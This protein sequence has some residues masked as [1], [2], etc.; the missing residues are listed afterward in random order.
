MPSETPE[1]TQ[2]QRGLT[3]SVLLDAIERNQELLS[4]IERF[5]DACCDAEPLLVNVRA[6]MNMNAI[7]LR[8]GG[9][10]Q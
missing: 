1:P 7:A 5:V 2:E 10:A 6:L 8:S 3:T 9:R 4:F